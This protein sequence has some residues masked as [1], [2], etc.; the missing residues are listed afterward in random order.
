[1]WI[2]NR[3][4]TVLPAPECMR[5]LAV[6]AKDTA[7]GRIGLATDQA[8][9]VVP[10]NFTLYGNQVLLRVGTGFISHAAIG[11]LVAFEVDHLDHATN[12][13]WSVLVRGLAMLIDDQDEA[14]IAAAPRPLVAEPG[15][16]VLAIRPDIVSGR[17]FDIHRTQ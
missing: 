14:P 8:P 17:R 15:D 10:V 3:G 6:A 2:D 1:M 9:V 4:S 5:L 11:H 12:S 13:A 16:M 7:L